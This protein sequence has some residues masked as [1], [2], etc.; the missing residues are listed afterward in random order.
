VA[1]SKRQVG[2]MADDEGPVEALVPEEGVG[3][4]D[5][6]EKIALEALDRWIYDLGDEEHELRAELR[7]AK[8]DLEAELKASL[9]AGNAWRPKTKAPAKRAPAKKKATT[10]RTAQTRAK[11]R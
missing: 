4:D 1:F 3:P 11:R 10:A 2:S 7:R 8:A 6:A 9:A 5:P